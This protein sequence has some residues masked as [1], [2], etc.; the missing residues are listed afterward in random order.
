ML[1]FDTPID[2]QMQQFWNW[3]T[4]ELGSLVPAWV[5]KIFGG[6]AEYL[7]ISR[8]ENGTTLSHLK[9]DSESLLASF[10]ADESGTEARE[11]YLRDNAQYAELKKV[12]RLTG[13]QGLRK[14]IK[15][16]MAAEENLSQVVSFEM[17]R[18]TPFKSDQIYFSTVIVN[19]LKATRQIVVDLML[20][21]RVKLDG[22]LEDLSLSGWRPDLVYLAGEGKPGTYNLLPEKFKPPRNRW[23]DY[24]NLALTV[25][26]G[27]LIAMLTI[28]P[29]WSAH[30][31]SQH[32]Q[33]EVKRVGKIA[34]DVESMR[35]ESDKLLHQARFLQDKKHVEPV[36]VDTL[37]ELSRVIPDGTWLN[38]LQ[39]AN[40]RLTIQGLSPSASSLIQRIDA[41]AFFRNVSFVSPVT[42]DASNGLER[43]Q[44]AGEV[45][46]GRFSEKPQ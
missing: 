43:F 25:I 9:S 35:E 30:S 37:E 22:L 3:W 26:I 39:F 1:K 21:P 4:G 33:A 10:P 28:L 17:D 27:S 31:E 15:L 2:I 14:Q 8:D 20:T 24:I 41:S 36:L 32:L 42:K 7:V 13:T 44:I 45:V 5:Q 23:P 12:L 46:N 29:I 11:Q 34:K 18:M 6:G 40:R 16:P 38:G 19:R